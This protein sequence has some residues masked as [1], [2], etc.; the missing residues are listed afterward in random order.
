MNILKISSFLFPLVACLLR[1][2]REAYIWTFRSHIGSILLSN[3]L[4]SPYRGMSNYSNFPSFPASFVGGRI[5]PR[6][7]LGS[8]FYSCFF[9]GRSFWGYPRDDSGD[10]FEASSFSEAWR[11]W[12]PFRD[13][14][15]RDSKEIFPATIYGVD[16]PYWIWTC[17]SWKGK[18]SGCL[19]GFLEAWRKGQYTCLDRRSFIVL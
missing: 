9:M 3:P 12:T 11:R 17:S 5:C 14:R 4:C 2:H 13:S 19:Q 8:P 6:Y 1:E 15:E 18:W 10:S 16:E 7:I